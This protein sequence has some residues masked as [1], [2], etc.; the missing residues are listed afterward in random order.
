MFEIM[1]GSVVVPILLLLGTVKLFLGLIDLLAALNRQFLRSKMDHLTRYGGKGTWALVTG[2]TDGIGLEFCKQL[3]RDGFNICLVSRTESKLQT[4]VERD[5]KELGVQTRIVVANFSGSHN[6]AFYDAIMAQTADIDIGLV[7]L[8]AGV[9][10]LSFFEEAEGAK[11]QE[12]IDTNV[13]QVGA[14]TSKMTARLEKR[15]KRSGIVAVSSIG[16]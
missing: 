6:M 15:G 11:L 7:V 14:L 4:V 1:I 9:D 10:H 13:Y 2:A 3:A 8:N 16:G 12:M 5:L